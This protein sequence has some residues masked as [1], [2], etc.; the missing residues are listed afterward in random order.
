[1]KQSC[2]PCYYDKLTKY[3][4]LCNIVNSELYSQVTT[5]KYAH[6]RKQLGAVIAEVNRTLKEHWRE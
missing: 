5:G 4:L 3:V 1:M 2:P 6:L